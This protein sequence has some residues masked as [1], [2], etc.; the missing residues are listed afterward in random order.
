MIKKICG[1]YG[2]GFEQLLLQVCKHGDVLEG[3]PLIYTDEI[4]DYLPS[5]ADVELYGETSLALKITGNVEP[6]VDEDEFDKT[7]F[8]LLDVSERDGLFYLI[9]DGDFFT[10]EPHDVVIFDHKK[11]HAIMTN[12]AWKAVA[13]PY[14]EKGKF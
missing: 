14:F 6:H 7:L 2:R 3:S 4:V 13:I 11:T 5:C 10:M 8:I 12:M 9:C 1:M